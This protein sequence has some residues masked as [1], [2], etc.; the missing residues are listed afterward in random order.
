MKYNSKISQNNKMDVIAENIAKLSI[1]QI[2]LISVANG[3]SSK[4]YRKR[5]NI[6]PDVEYF[7]NRLLFGGVYF[8]RIQEWTTLFDS[9]HFVFTSSDDFYG[10]TTKFMV[11]L[12]RFLNV[13]EQGMEFWRNITSNVY[14]VNL[15]KGHGYQ[16]KEQ[17]IEDVEHF[18]L[19]KNSLTKIAHYSENRMLGTQEIVDILRNYYKPYNHKLAEV[20]NGVM[21]NGWDY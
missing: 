12:E 15:A 5:W 3:I 21:Y 11:K 8:E 9:K 16:H 20:L 10:N 4:F 14:N 6:I 7:I 18:N 13:D 2:I 19:D 17:K 1:Y